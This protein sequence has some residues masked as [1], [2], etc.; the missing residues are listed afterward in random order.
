VKLIWKPLVGL[1]SVGILFGCATIV[2]GTDQTVTV[3]TTP[4]GAICELKRGAHMMSIVNPTP[5]TAMIEKSKKDIT[6]TCNKEGHHTGVATLKSEFQGMTFGNI[7]FGGIIG[8][9]IDAGSGAMHKY[10][11]SVHVTLFPEEFETE[12]SRDQFFDT[13]NARIESEAAKA[14]AL[15]RK[16]C[17]PDQV[18]QCDKTVAAIENERDAQ[19]AE[20]EAKRAQAKIADQTP[21]S[22]P[23]T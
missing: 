1:A 7:L 6:I 4:G 11:P 17:V 9:A 5:G 15:I 14:V 22:T 3:T 2:K 23:G 10:K 13:E 19:I 16:K 21:T 18:D 12:V 8:V 20:L